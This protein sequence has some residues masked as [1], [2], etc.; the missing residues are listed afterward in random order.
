VGEMAEIVTAVT[1][2]RFEATEAVADELVL[3][4]ILSILRAALTI[5][6]AALTDAAVCEMMETCF[7]MCFQ[8]RLSGAF[9]RHQSAIFYIVLLFI[10]LLMIELLR[11]QSEQTILAMVQLMLEKYIVI[12]K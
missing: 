12:F 3:M 5:P 6:D 10:F 8:M 1:H 9:P 4:K 2:C 7:S 11:K